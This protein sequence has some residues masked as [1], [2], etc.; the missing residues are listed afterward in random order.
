MVKKTVAAETAQYEVV[1]RIEDGAWR[2]GG[3]ASGG[4]CVDNCVIK[5]RYTEEVYTARA[6]AAVLVKVA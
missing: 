3:G 4:D 2:R 5:C 6:A 1:C